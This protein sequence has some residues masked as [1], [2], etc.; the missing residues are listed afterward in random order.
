MRLKPNHSHYLII[1]A[2]A[3]LVGVGW[4]W[5][6]HQERNQTITADQANSAN[7]SVLSAQDEATANANLQPIENVNTT[8][9]EMIDT[10]QAE[11]QT[12]T[13]P[14]QPEPVKAPQTEYIKNA[15][16]A[17]FI[18]GQAGPAA[19]VFPKDSRLLLVLETSIRSG[20]KVESKIAVE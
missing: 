2:G 1:L 6:G 3:L 20:Q 7:A 17:E 14:D 10:N 15:H 4:Y 12:Q 9:D 5:Y 18:D 19:S 16:L 11:P 13:E 8:S